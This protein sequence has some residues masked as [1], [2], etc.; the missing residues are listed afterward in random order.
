MRVRCL[1]PSRS[2]AVHFNLPSHPWH[3]NLL[4]LQ[5]RN[6]S[7]PSRSTHDQWM[8]PRLPMGAR[9]TLPSSSVNTF[10]LETARMMTVEPCEGTQVPDLWPWVGSAR[11]CSE[12][13]AGVKT[14]QLSM[15][16][17]DASLDWQYSDDMLGARRTVPVLDGEA[18]PSMSLWMASVDAGI[19][20]GKER[21]RPRRLFRF[22]TA[23]SSLPRGHD[24]QHGTAKA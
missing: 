20:R 21:P 10:S 22:G 9:T 7:Q 18:G 6:P 15:F 23:C 1:Q 17:R 14:L 13:A 11:V 3:I 12:V 24:A 4:E 5:F 19:M 8:E 16:E 2:S